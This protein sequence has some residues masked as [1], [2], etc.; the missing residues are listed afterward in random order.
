MGTEMGH[1]GGAKF[2]TAAISAPASG[3]GPSPTPLD[4]RYFPGFSYLLGPPPDSQRSTL[5][6]NPD[7]ARQVLSALHSLL[8]TGVTEDNTRIPA[9]YTYLLQLVAHDLV[10]TTVPFWVA[11]ETGVTSRNMRGATLELDTLYGGGPTV[12]PI[13]FTPAG[14][15]PDFR[16][17]LR[18]GRVPD[19]AAPGPATGACPFRDL[20]RLKLTA[21][22]TAPSNLT[23]ASQVYIA[24]PR[25]DDNVLVAQIAVLFSILHN[26]IARRMSQQIPQAQ[27]AHART[28]I[29]Q[30]FYAIIRNDLMPLLLHDAVYQL[31]RERPVS[32]DAWLW[33]GLE[34]PLEF[35]HGAFRVGHA[36]VRPYYVFN[37]GNTFALDGVIGGPTIGAAIRDPLPANWIVAWSKFFD[38]SGTPNYSL[39]LAVRQAVP[40]DGRK[41]LADVAADTP[42]QLTLRDWLS[43]ATARMWR[44]DALLG[45]VRQRYPGLSFIGPAAI[46]QWLAG[47][48]RTTPGMADAKAL[49]SQNAALLAAD[50]PL[51]LY[52]LLESQIDPAI[53]GAHLGPLGSVLIG[54]VLFRRL[55]EGE[56]KLAH[57]LPA[58][59]QVLGAQDWSR[60]DA[61]K[62][63]P[64]LVRLA[65]DWGGLADCPQMPFIAAA[66]R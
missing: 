2:G 30:M 40:L 31:L 49:V 61:V 1:G 27:F 43:A 41:L 9:G 52:V 19:A 21:P 13:A 60:I 23:D 8:P 4:P 26:A 39:K 37:D 55:A 14:N 57:L 56:A 65:E 53:A 34:V 7:N 11:A 66:T 51:P 64:A 38:L 63:M 25:N 16:A 58:A 62:S 48:L 24:D 17:Q 59:Q 42:V 50:L 20:A 54:E 44:L 47:L 3:G 12:C 15:Q 45:A 36:M 6:G 29:L 33:H 5:G 32:S 22:P 10:E 35:T 46:S 18:L 28:A